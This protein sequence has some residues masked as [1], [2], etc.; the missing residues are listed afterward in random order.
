[1]GHSLVENMALGRVVLTTDAP[2]MN[3]LIQPDRGLLVPGAAQRRHRLGTCYQVDVNALET[4]LINAF[5]MSDAELR[6]LQASAQDWYA[7]QHSKLVTRLM[8]YLGITG[9]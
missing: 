1:F 4:V 2:P 8:V 7:D 9:I 6:R 5:A 3:E